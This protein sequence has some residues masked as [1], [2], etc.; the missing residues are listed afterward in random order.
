M[1]AQTP[2]SK[3]LLLYSTLRSFLISIIKK[4]EHGR[5]FVRKLF[6]SF[7]LDSDFAHAIPPQQLF[8]MTDLQIATMVW[9]MQVSSFQNIISRFPAERV[10]TLDA[11]TLLAD[12]TRTLVGLD[13]FF[14]L[15]IGADQLEA[16]ANGPT[17]KTNSKNE[18]ESFDASVRANE[19]DDVERGFGPDLDLMV[20]WAAKTWPQLRPLEPLPRKLLS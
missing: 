20:G 7:N 1:L 15:G 8:Q 5:N 18:R 4:R 10:V 12:P 16:I 17:F 9:L 6:S 19:S 13:A 11:D 3:A 2:A 14:E